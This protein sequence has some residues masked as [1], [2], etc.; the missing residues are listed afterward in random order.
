LFCA[1]LSLL[2]LLVRVA[3]VKK[4][5][6]SCTLR[7]IPFKNRYWA[8]SEHGNIFSSALFGRPNRSPF[9]SRQSNKLDTRKIK[10][11]QSLNGNGDFV[12]AVYASPYDRKL[13]LVAELVCEA[14]NGKRPSPSH[15]IWF[16]DGNR[17][18]CAASN[19]VWMPQ[20]GAALRKLDRLASP[21]VQIKP[22]PFENYWATSDGRIISTKFRRANALSPGVSWHGYSRVVLYLRGNKRAYYVHRLIALAF[23]GSPP[24]GR[25]QV[26]HI[27][28]LKSNNCVSN[29][30][31]SD[32]YENNVLDKAAHGHLKLNSEAAQEI[33]GG[34][35][36]GIPRTALAEA[37]GV[38]VSTIGLISI[39][40]TWREPESGVLV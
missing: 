22:L 34:I 12:I 2:I 21:G 3:S 5:S 10:L 27:D 19:L 40:R 24:P 8:C 17:L 25:N 33:R 6:L 38:S 37:F 16:I 1:I 29:L 31:Y 26:A 4:C 32:Q 35:T 13:R 7:P 14:F 30:K 36:Q 23:M 20:P 18:N 39:G 15:S 9:R 28:G 11:K